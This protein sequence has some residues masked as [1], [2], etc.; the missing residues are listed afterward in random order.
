MSL[1]EKPDPPHQTRIIN[2]FLKHHPQVAEAIALASTIV[3]K[4]QFPINSFQDLS[5]A[6]GTHTAVQFGG[7]SFTL[8]ELECQIPSYYF[9]IANEND[10]IAKIGDLSKRLPSV[11]TPAPTLIPATASV[12]SVAPPTLSHEE[13]RQASGYMAEGASAV[14]GIKR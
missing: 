14:G 8:V 5:E 4:A 1:S 9:P 3:S 11:G 12:P 2:V 6:M 7:R 13:I 10:L